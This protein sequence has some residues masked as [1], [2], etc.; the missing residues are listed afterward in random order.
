[1]Y[2]NLR[3]NTKFEALFVESPALPMV[4]IQLTFNAGSARDVEVEKGL[5]GVANMAA[6]LHR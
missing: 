4:D 5:Y 3:T 2:T 6:Q 1:M